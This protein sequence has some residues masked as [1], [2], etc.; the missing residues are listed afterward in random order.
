MG[1]WDAVIKLLDVA[2]VLAMPVILWYLARNKT[3]NDRI[4]RQVNGN[5]HEALEKVDV[6]HAQLLKHGIE[7]KQVE[8]HKKI[9]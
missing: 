3:Q 6:Y 8:P 4:E 9:K 1:P 5:L 2:S 7:P